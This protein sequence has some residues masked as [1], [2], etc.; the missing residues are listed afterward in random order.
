MRT[1]LRHIITDTTLSFNQ[2]IACDQ[3]TAI[4]Q[5]LRAVVDNVP[6]LNK[7]HNSLNKYYLLAQ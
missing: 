5:P 1:V 2:C 3:K 4:Y 7:S 6:C